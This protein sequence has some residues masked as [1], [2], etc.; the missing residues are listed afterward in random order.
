[1]KQETS[2]MWSS[3]K[4]KEV[5]QETPAEHD[6]INL[7]SYGL[8]PG[9]LN[10]FNEAFLNSAK[11]GGRDADFDALLISYMK[12]LCEGVPNGKVRVAL[13]SFSP[14]QGES[15]RVKISS[16]KGDPSTNARVFDVEAT[17]Y[18]TKLL[19]CVKKKQDNFNFMM[20]IAEAIKNK[21]GVCYLNQKMLMQYFP[22]VRVADV[23]G[24]DRYDGSIDM[25]AL[26]A[27]LDDQRKNFQD[28]NNQVQNSSYDMIRLS[29]VNTILKRLN[30]KLIQKPKY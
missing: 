30:Q 23:K 16:Q 9:T 12:E 1:M 28:I 7:N 20:P 14:S 21:S 13:G 6:S 17:K 3:R 2:P 15:C 8:I 29:S 10:G 11:S 26:P 4:Q 25:T 24:V 22:S 18:A 27:L 5:E 19:E